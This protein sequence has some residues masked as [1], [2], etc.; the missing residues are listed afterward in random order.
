VLPLSRQIP[1]QPILAVH[2]P[3]VD[4]PRVTVGVTIVPIAQLARVVLDSKV[5]LSATDV[6][7]VATAAGG[8]TALRVAARARPDVVVL[9]LDLPDRDGTT[10][11][12]E[13][14]G[15]TTVPIIV[16]SRHTD[17]E[18]MVRA[19]TPAPTTTSRNPSGD[20]SSSPGCAPC[21][22]ARSRHPTATR[23]GS[24]TP[25]RSPSI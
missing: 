16:L 3:T 8:V 14:R 6:D 19:L 1:I 2:G 9:E 20:P 22:A 4:R 15:W 25:A 24:S 10:M 5:V 17:S 11:I 13:L 18:H 23:T 21:C 7:P 12:A